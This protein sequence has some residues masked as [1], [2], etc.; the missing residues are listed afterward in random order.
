MFSKFKITVFTI[1]CGIF[2]FSSIAFGQKT[3]QPLK[4]SPTPVSKK[5]KIEFSDI[6][7]W[8]KSIAA[9]SDDEYIVNYD[10]ETSGRVT[11]YVYNRGLEQIPS[12][13]TDKLIVEEFEGAQAAVM[14]LADLGIYENVKQEKNETINLGGASGKLKSLRA[15]M[16]MTMRG[17]NMVSETYLFGHQNRFVKIRATRSKAQNDSDKNKMSELL[18]EIDKS[19]SK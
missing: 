11:I 6:E 8:E 9:D 4:P 5:S 15:K 2:L 12:G 10:S 16:T 17:Q 19:L 3:D 7:G 18:G 14:Q 1:V 13:V